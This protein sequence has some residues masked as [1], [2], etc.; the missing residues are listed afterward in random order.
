MMVTAVRYSM[1]ENPEGSG[2][3]DR[4]VR[5]PELRRIQQTHRGVRHWPARQ[6]LID[7]LI[8]NGHIAPADGPVW[9]ADWDQ[10]RFPSLIV[11]TEGAIAL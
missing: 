11:A 1:L 7:V 10:R 9:G 3:A 6:M 2:R 4:L 8:V 5:V